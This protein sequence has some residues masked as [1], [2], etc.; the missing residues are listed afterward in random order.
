MSK[1][2]GGPAFPSVPHET[3]GMTLRDW[4][5]GMVASGMNANSSMDNMGPQTLAENAYAQA[6]AMIAEREKA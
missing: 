4:F 1:P 6:D 5:A 3:P 2:D